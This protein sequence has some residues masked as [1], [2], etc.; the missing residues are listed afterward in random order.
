MAAGRKKKK[1]R[2]GLLLV[3]LVVV[4]MIAVIMVRSVALRRELQENQATEA[5]LQAELDRENER[6]KEI[7]DYATYTK[8]REFVEE[9]AKDKLGLVYEGETVFKNEGNQ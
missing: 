9:T 5:A 2:S 4:A 8:T 1:N 7:E 3:M 6:T